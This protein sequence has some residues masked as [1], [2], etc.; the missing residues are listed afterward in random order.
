MKIIEIPNHPD[1]VLTTA[2]WCAMEGVPL[3]GAPK[4]AVLDLLNASLGYLA[5]DEIEPASPRDTKEYA[6]ET[7]DEME[8]KFQ[9]LGDDDADRRIFQ[10]IA[11]VLRKPLP[12]SK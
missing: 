10:V 9:W 1:E 3:V 2:R 5:P 8:S 6:D 12:E 11:D 7:A 4:S